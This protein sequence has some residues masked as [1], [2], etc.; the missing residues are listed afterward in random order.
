MCLVPSSTAR[1]STLPASSGRTTAAN[2]GH[3][4]STTPP[5]FAWCSTESRPSSCLW[6]SSW[7]PSSGTRPAPSTFTKRKRSRMPPSQR[8]RTTWLPRPRQSRRCTPKPSH[9]CER[10][11]H[12]HL[13][14]SLGLYVKK[15]DAVVTSG[16]WLSSFVFFPFG[17]NLFG[18]RS[19]WALQIIGAAIVQCSLS[20]WSHQLKKKKLSVAHFDT[21][22]VLAVWGRS[23]HVG[24]RNTMC[25]KCQSYLLP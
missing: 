1:S 12:L 6:P 14:K 18:Q 19:W 10:C 25:P 3:A 2:P 15:N 22:A 24:T 21:A 4:V 7:M 23:V 13:Y 11:T 9:A 20:L 17:W 16:L 5:S 8:Q